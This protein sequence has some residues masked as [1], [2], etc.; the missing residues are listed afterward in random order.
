MVAEPDHRAPQRHVVE[1]FRARRRPRADRARARRAAPASCS[2]RKRERRQ[3]DVER[4]PLDERVEVGLEAQRLAHRDRRRPAARGWRARAAAPCAARSTFV[5]RIA[6]ASWRLPSIVASIARDQSPAALE[7]RVDQSQVRESRP[8]RSSDRPSTGAAASGS[9]SRWSAGSA[10][11]ARRERRRGHETSDDPAR[12]LAPAARRHPLALDHLAEDRQLL[13]QLLGRAVLDHPAVGDHHHP[14]GAAREPGRMRDHEGGSPPHQTIEPSHQLVLAC[15]VE[16]GGRLVED[17]DRRVAKQDARDP[18]PLALA[19]GEPDPGGSELGV[20][21]VRQPVDELVRARYLCR[22]DHRLA[23]GAVWRRTRCSRRRC[24]RTASSP[25]A[26][27]RPG[28]AATASEHSRASRPSIST[29][30]C[31]GSYSRATRAPTVDLPAPDGPTSATRDPAGT[32]S[33]RSV[34]AGAVRRVA[35]R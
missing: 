34:S 13:E 16:A 1:A 5:S 2:E 3:G 18:D 31:S 6:T 33:D 32:C 19:A 23:R 35:E 7:L 4:Q 25:G 15:R 11:S 26:G 24:R 27:S 21:A 29:L 20:V 14:L 8:R 30:P 17:Q 10:G 12:A 9:S 28:R 22:L